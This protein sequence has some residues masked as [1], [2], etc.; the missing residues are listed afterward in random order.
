MSPAKDYTPRTM[1]RRDEHSRAEAVRQLGFGESQAQKG[2]PP[3]DGSDK[4]P[5][6]KLLLLVDALRMGW[7][8]GGRTTPS[9]SVTAGLLRAHDEGFKNPFSSNAVGDVWDE[10]ISGDLE[11]QIRGRRKTIVELYEDAIPGVVLETY[12]EVEDWGERLSDVRFCKVCL[13]GRNLPPTT[14]YLNA[15]PTLSPRLQRSTTTS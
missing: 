8:K 10:Y 11:R 7:V 1:H 4:D 6:T 12:R 3:R 5:A 9:A 2:I 13:R 14:T 15:R